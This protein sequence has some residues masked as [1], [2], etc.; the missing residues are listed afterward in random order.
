MAIQKEQIIQ[1]ALALLDELGIEGITMRKLAR[2]L[3]IQAASLYWHFANKQALMDGLAD[4]LM[5]DVARKPMRKNSWDERV[6]KVANEIRRAMLKHRDGA[7]VFAGTYGITENVL[8]VGDTLIAALTEAGA[9]TRLASWGTFSVL[10]YVLGFV[11]EEQALG[12]DNGIDMK[13]RQAA[14]LKMAGKSYRHAYEAAD[15]IFERN[16]DQ[17][18]GFGLD[19]LVLGLEGKIN[20]HQSSNF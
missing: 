14:F 4:I 6:R 11:M 2:S 20:S 15:D 8:R 1:V 7:R 10:Y 12:P 9:P 13:Q 16:F 5:E 18:F 17:R 19:V 3:D